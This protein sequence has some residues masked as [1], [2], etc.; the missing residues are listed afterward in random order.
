MNEYSK[1]TQ[2][3]TKQDKCTAYDMCH[4]RKKV[5]KVTR[6]DWKSENFKEELR[7][8]CRIGVRCVHLSPA[9]VLTE[10]GVHWHWRWQRR[11]IVRGG[12]RRGQKPLLQQVDHLAHETRTPLLK[13]LEFRRERRPALLE[14]GTAA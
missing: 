8:N 5:L 12:W 1:M 9:H 7:E 11:Q 4:T 2:N 3:E 10:F 6:V 14:T 13:R